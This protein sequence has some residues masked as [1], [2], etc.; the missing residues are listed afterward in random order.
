[1]SLRDWESWEAVLRRLITGLG[2]LVGLSWDKAFDV[3]ELGIVYGFENSFAR[4]PVISRVALALGLVAFILP[5]WVW[6]I[7]PYAQM[8][9]ARWI[10]LIIRER[11][12]VGEEANRDV[13]SLLQ[14]DAAE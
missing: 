5:A 1:M 7:V 8:S 6:Y 3:A 11:E 12:A 4:R 2:L 14:S 13:R 10:E 9:E